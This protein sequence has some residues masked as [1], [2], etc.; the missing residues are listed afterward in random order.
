[1]PRLRSEALVI[2]V[3]RACPLGKREATVA[4][5]VQ[6]R[7]AG[8]RAGGRGSRGEARRVDGHRVGSWEVNYSTENLDYLQNHDWL[9]QESNRVLVQWPEALHEAWGQ[10]A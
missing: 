9:K 7:P 6:E 3:L 4:M 5:S 10:A 1:M 8:E 2:L